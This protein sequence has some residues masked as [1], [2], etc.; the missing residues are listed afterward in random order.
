MYDDADHKDGEC[1]AHKGRRVLHRG[2]DVERFCR[3]EREEDRISYTPAAEISA[4][5]G[6]IEVHR[7]RPSRIKIK[8]P[9]RQRRVLAALRARVEI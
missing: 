5:R 4:R 3:E 7:P 6:T 2:K 8:N 9:A 1:R